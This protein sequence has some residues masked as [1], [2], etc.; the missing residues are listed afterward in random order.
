MYIPL[1]RAN[2]GL[3][4]SEGLLASGIY[5]RIEIRL[6][7]AHPVIKDAIDVRYFVSMISSF[8]DRPSSLNNR[9]TR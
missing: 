9:D 5:F 6:P 8:I 4:L 7:L 2:V 1:Q 3:S